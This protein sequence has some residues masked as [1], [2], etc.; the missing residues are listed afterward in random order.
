MEEMAK[1]YAENI[2]RVKAH[3][4][5][6]KKER[7]YQKSF[8]VKRKISDRIKTHEH[9]LMCLQKDYYNITNYY[10]TEKVGAL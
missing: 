1:E 8:E 5:T 9:L 10:K 6:L 3:I 4:E 7:K 2:A